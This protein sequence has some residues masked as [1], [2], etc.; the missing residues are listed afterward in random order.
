MQKQTYGLMEQNR[1]INPHS[2]GQLSLAKEA[3][4][5]KGKKIVSLA[6]GIGKV[7]QF[8]SVAQSCQTFCKPMDCSMSG[9]PVHHQL[10]TH[11]S[12]KLEHI[13][14]PCT[15]INSKWLKDLNIRYNTIKLPEEGTG[16]YYL[17]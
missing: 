17:T 11:K 6:S 3:Q 10:S 8:S 7:G 2:Y 16:K 13:L 12:M 9:F 14:T 1:V 5:F 4:I 15:K